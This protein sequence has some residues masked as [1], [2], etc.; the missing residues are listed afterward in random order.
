MAFCALLTSGPATGVHQLRGIAQEES[1]DARAVL[2]WQLLHAG[3][4]ESWLCGGEIVREDRSC[5]V[6]G[7]SRRSTSELEAAEV[8]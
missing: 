8:F 1:W 7:I 2:K 4:L 5:T 6:V 3:V